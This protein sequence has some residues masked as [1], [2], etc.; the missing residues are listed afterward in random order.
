M[1]QI[2]IF[3][4]LITSSVFCSDFSKI[5]TI[6]SSFR[7]V[8]SPEDLAKQINS[9]FT[10]DE[11]KVKASFYWLATNINYDIIALSSSNKQY[12]FT[13]T[14]KADKQR[15]IKAIEDKFINETFTKRKGICE[16]YALSL[17]K[18]CDLLKIPC[19]TIN[20]N[21]RVDISEIGRINKDTN[22]AWNLVYVNNKWIFIDTTWAA[23]FAINGKWN[24]SFNSY[25]YNTPKNKAVKTHYSNNLLWNKHFNKLS[26]TNFY[27]Q[28]IYKL[29]FLETKAEIIAPKSGFIKVNKNNKIELS[30]KN[31]DPNIIV[32]YVYSGDKYASFPNSI[33][34]GSNTILIFESPKNSTSLNVFFGNRLALQYKIL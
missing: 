33:K 11:D 8:N 22:H 19:K 27:N 6:V 28:P 25:F 20:G 10:T 4:L 26:L 7:N 29:R 32:Q 14:D 3:F 16:E 31:L 17:K 9:N 15:K 21:V 12:R 13:Y 24:K 2:L 30:L 23:G 5:H 1:K 18:L 34:N